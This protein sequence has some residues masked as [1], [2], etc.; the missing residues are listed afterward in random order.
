MHKADTIETARRN[1]GTSRI[2]D[3]ASDREH[4]VDRYGRRA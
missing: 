1:C 3:K 2:L 4:A